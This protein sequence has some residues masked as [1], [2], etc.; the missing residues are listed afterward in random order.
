MRSKIFVSVAILILLPQV[1]FASWWNPFTW[2]IF[3]KPVEVKI[4]KT[5]TSSVEELKK[6]T[7]PA[8]SVPKPYIPPTVS[9]TNSEQPK[10]QIQNS[11]PVVM[12][13]WGQQEVRDFAYANEMGWASLISTNSLGEKRYY[14]KENNIWVLKNSEAE[15]KQPFIPPPTSEELNAFNK[16]CREVPDFCKDPKVYSSYLTNLSFRELTNGL[17]RKYNVEMSNQAQIR[18]QQANSAQKQQLECLM[19]LTPESERTLSPAT[20]NYLRKLRCGT[21]TS[22]DKTNYE[23]SQIGSK[24]SD[25]EHRLKNKET[26][27]SSLIN[28]ILPLP[29]TNKW[30]V[31]WISNDRGFIQDSSGKTTNFQCDSIRG[32][33][34]SI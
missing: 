14:R 32:S 28:E 19:A 30:R 26:F 1:T 17:I 16:V 24:I 8:V 12:E 2:K 3:N 34:S 4:E 15:I 6:K 33:C 9:N 18:V 21:S 25:L 22:A 11:K 10:P 13:T 20:Q 27:P 7:S 23:L 29:S 5:I 31:Q